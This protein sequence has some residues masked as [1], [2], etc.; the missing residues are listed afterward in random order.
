ML[1]DSAILSHL[2]VSF[3]AGVSLVALTG[4]LKSRCFPNQAKL[5][6]PPG[7]RGLPLVGNILDLPRDMPIW[8]GFMQMAETYRTS[9]VLAFR[10][11]H[12]LIPRAETEVMYLNMFGTNIVVLNSSEAVADLMDKRSAIYSDKVAASITLLW[13]TSN[14][15]VAPPRNSLDLPCWN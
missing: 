5:P 14:A 13:S 11:T 9:T 12:N 15:I 2:I 3:G 8:K 6:Y 10:W 4:Y 1:D 7:P